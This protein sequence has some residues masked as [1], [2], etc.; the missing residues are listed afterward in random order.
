MPH[1]SRNMS[2]E[3]GAAFEDA[4]VYATQTFWKIF[5]TTVRLACIAGAGFSL[6]WGERAVAHSAFDHG[7]R[8]VRS[9]CVQR[10]RLSFASSPVRAADVFERAEFCRE[11]SYIGLSANVC[12]RSIL[13]LPQN[14]FRLFRG[15]SIGHFLSRVIGAYGPLIA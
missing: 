6:D 3:A 4:L 12:C 5:C 11:R 8:S 2:C 13:N 14:I 10:Q 7:S 9:R 1:R 15:F